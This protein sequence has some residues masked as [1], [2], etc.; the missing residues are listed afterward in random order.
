[1]AAYDWLDLATGSDT[2]SSM[3]R[4]A[5][6]AGVYGNRP[7]HDIISLEGVVPLV[8]RQD[9]LGIF[10]RD[11]VLWNKA[12]HAWYADSPLQLIDYKGVPSKVLYV[13]VF[14]EPWNASS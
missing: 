12:A 10:S 7:S 9:T 14:P 2:G 8:L 13:R 3:R 11:A 6:V 5:A 4:P 1:M